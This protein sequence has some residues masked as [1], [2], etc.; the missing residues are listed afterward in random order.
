MLTVADG[1]LRHMY[2]LSILKEIAIEVFF[3]SYFGK[4]KKEVFTKMR[5]KSFGGKLQIVEIST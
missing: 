5:Q 2:S 4:N 1:T 3:G